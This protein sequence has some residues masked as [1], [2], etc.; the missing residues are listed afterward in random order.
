MQETLLQHFYFP[1]SGFVSVP[2]V[3][4]FMF[5][6]SRLVDVIF[7]CAKLILRISNLSDFI[8]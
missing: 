5:G 2:F 1:Y 8:A 3:L 7:V 4:S 6:M